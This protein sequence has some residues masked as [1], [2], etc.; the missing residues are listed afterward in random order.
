V[1]DGKKRWRRSEKD[2]EGERRDITMK[3][4]RTKLIEKDPL[5]EFTIAK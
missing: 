1:A 4:E 5:D 3:E 2:E